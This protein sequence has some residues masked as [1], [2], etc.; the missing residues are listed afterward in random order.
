MNGGVGEKIRLKEGRLLVPD[1]PVIPFIEGDG[2]GR[3]IVKPSLEVIDAAVERA[4]AGQRKIYW[5]EV[6]AGEKAQK[7]CGTPLPQETIDEIREHLVALKGPLMTPVGSG[8]RSLNVTLRQVLD[9][10][11]CIR[12][13]K[14]LAGVPSPLRN[15]ERMDL[16]I[17]RENT[18]DLYAGIEWKSGS[19]GARRVISFLEEEFDI[20]LAPEAG[21]GLKPISPRA[22]KRLVRKAIEYATAHDR[23]V[24]TL[25]HKGNIMKYTEGAFM[26]WG[27]EVAQEEFPELVITEAELWERYHGQLPE[28]KILINDRIADNMFQLLALEPEKYDILVTPNLNGDYL[29]DAAA[30][31]VGGVGLIPGANI[32]DYIGLFEPTHGTAPDIAGQNKANPTAFILSGAMLLEYIGW[33]E[34]AA[35]LRQALEK[36]IQEG[37]VTEDLA[38]SMEIKEGARGLSTLDFTRVVIENIQLL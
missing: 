26:Q 21:L 38:R 16:V 30:G 13:I 37:K 11:A 7:E 32:G 23:H 20:K 5:K 9:L 35:L 1:K 29:S 12:P 36:A 22:T 2:I 34:A 31:L 6:Y 27:Y 10:Y 17:F 18:E 28:G 24:V 15:P 14:H 33:G 8:F 3:D 25:V 4:Y 19:E